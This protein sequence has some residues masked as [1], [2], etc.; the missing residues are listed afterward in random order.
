MRSLLFTGWE[1]PIGA[2]SHCVTIGDF[3]HISNIGRQTCSADRPNTWQL[4]GMSASA[5]PMIPP[6][7][8]PKYYHLHPLNLP[9]YREPN[10]SRLKNKGEVLHLLYWSQLVAKK[11]LHKGGYH[12][13]DIGAVESELGM[14]RSKAT[15]KW[16]NYR[17][18][19]KGRQR[20]QWKLL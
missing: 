19:I 17:I 15:T 5:V 9:W 7:L 20:T 2:S 18:K 14:N 10:I 13:G 16:R 4:I 11:N 3:C 6:A 1:N 12:S 8:P